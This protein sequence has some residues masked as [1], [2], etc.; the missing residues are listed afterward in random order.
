[1]LEEVSVQSGYAL[2]IKEPTDGKGTA[3]VT[4]PP[5]SSA[6]ATSTLDLQLR[7]LLAAGHSFLFIGGGVCS[8]AARSSHSQGVQQRTLDSVDNKKISFSPASR[9]GRCRRR[10]GG[11]QHRGWKEQMMHRAGGL[12][13]RGERLG[14]APKPAAK[15]NAIET[16]CVSGTLHPAQGQL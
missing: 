11:R 10:D 8:R 15:K 3:F 13:G 7:G 6:R 5:P 4:Y 16:G 1:M 14:G 2:L 12:I 9:R